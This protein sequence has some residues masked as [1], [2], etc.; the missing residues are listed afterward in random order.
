MA[1]SIT[2]SYNNKSYTCNHQ[3]Y[4]DVRHDIQKFTSIT[5]VGDYAVSFIDSIYHSLLAKL[6]N[7]QDTFSMTVCYLVQGRKEFEDV[8][9]SCRVTDIEQTISDIDGKPQFKYIIKG[10]R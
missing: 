7:T 1:Q 5:F 2:I 3:F 10:K 6:Y 4:V 8:Y 9:N